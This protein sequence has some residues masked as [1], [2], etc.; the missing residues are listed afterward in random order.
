MLRPEFQ[1][2][3]GSR[4]LRLG[5]R[6]LV[7]GVVNATPDSFFDGGRHSSPERALAQARKLIEE[8]VDII[9]LGGES[10]RPQSKG[11][12][13]QEESA[14]VVPVIEAL[15]RETDL[16]ISIDTKKASVARAALEAGALIINDITGGRSDPE[17]LDLAGRTGCGLVLMHMRGAPADMQSRTDYADLNQE[18]RSELE[19]CVR[20]ALEAGV[21][22]ESIVL[23]PG[24]G[25]AKTPTQ[26]LKLIDRLEALAGLGYPLLVGPSRKSFIGF[27]LEAQGLAHAPDD[28]I[29]GTMA[30][31][32]LS[33]YLG[34]HILR[35]HDVGEARQVLAVAD[36]VREG[37]FIPV[38]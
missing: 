34:A 24:I 36:A 23:D 27:S 30:A 13:V 15:V 31:V 25:F 11:V 26:N 6:T 35:V 4:K 28:R 9:D 10:T 1:W 32:T 5:P 8:G 21:R 16:P 38:Q 7:M 22:P 29:W 20:A 37:T 3:L 18:V 19:E 2:E 17:M 14:R 12:S 33:A